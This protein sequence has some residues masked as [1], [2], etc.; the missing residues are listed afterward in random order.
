MEYLAER[1]QDQGYGDPEMR[2]HLK[3]PPIVDPTN[4]VYRTLW[5]RGT[6][7]YLS[8]DYQLFCFCF[9]H[10][11]EF[12]CMTGVLVVIESTV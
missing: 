6:S 12:L 1:F 2:Q 9:H 4:P 11:P 8:M 5:P 10:P 7:S 3:T